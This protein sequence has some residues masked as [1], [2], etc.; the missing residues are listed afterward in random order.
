MAG[1]GPE[2]MPNRLRTGVSHERHVDAQEVFR[3]ES[4]DR[5][6]LFSSRRSEALT[7]P[8]QDSKSDLCAL[9]AAQRTR[10]VPSLACVRVCAAQ[11][12]CVSRGDAD[13]GRFARGVEH[14]AEERSRRPERIDVHEIVPPVT[15]VS[16]YIA[17]VDNRGLVVLAKALAT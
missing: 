10:T 6:N 5:A 14:R 17:R 9:R 7:V 4:Q 15:P 16:G 3:G 13:S 2:H 1:A 8:E 11:D 12:R